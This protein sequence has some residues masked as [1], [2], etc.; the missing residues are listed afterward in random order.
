MHEFYVQT[1][2]KVSGKEICSQNESVIIK[3]RFPVLED[4]DFLGS[5][6]RVDSSSCIIESR[7]INK[8]AVCKALML[9]KDLDYFKF[10]WLRGTQ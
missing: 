2:S 5:I 6:F 7:E 10:V 8:S 1:C 9:E 3:S 4:L